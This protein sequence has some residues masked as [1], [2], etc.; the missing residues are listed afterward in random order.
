MSTLPGMV[1]AD[2]LA[3]QTA[4]AVIHCSFYT[5]GENHNQ[6]VVPTKKRH[7][8]GCRRVGTKMPE[9]SEEIS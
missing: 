4:A 1:G 9:E 8:G 6:A 2:L 7:P 5:T 3:Q